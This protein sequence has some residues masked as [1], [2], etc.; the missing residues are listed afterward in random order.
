MFYSFIFW[1]FFITA[2]FASKK[3]P[4]HYFLIFTERENE[5]FK[6]SDVFHMSR[7]AFDV[8]CICL[9]TRTIQ[10]FPKRT[11][12]AETDD[13]APKEGESVSM[14]VGTIYPLKNVLTSHNKMGSFGCYSLTN[15]TS[16]LRND[17]SVLGLLGCCNR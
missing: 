17:R 9:G 10:I 3:R 5:S 1:L 4:N 6:F 11:L 2:K 12:L 7:S 14:I 15:V 16:L 13:C 8:K